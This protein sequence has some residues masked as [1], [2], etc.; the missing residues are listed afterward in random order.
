MMR[1]MYKE[2]RDRITLI[3]HFC[4]A[5][6]FELVTGLSEDELQPCGVFKA[7]AGGTSR[8]GTSQSSTKGAPPTQAGSR[9]SPSTSRRTPT[10]SNSG[11]SI[12]RVQDEVVQI[13][14]EAIEGEKSF[15]SFFHLILPFF[16]GEII[17]DDLSFDILEALKNVDD[18]K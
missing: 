18:D 10:T 8:A 1:A 5:R 15:H 7:M 14:G 17:L 13:E 9:S 11:V 6:K 4:W 16:P 3:R 12:T 2:N